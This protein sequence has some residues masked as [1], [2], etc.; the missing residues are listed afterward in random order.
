MIKTGFLTTRFIYILRNFRNATFHV[1]CFL[2]WVDLRLFPIQYFILSH[3]KEQLTAK[4]IL[5]RPFVL[6]LVIFNK[7][8][9]ASIWINMK[10]NGKTQNVSEIVV[11]NLSQQKRFFVNV[12]L[13]FS[14]AH[15]RLIRFGYF[16]TC[17]SA[18]RHPNSYLAAQNVFGY[19]KFLGQK[20]SFT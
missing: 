9:I 14:M 17:S 4:Q 12:T 20:W 3:D 8:C 15:Y 11:Y 19:C 6:T 7:T 5:L 10:T 18:K 2:Y 13:K 16:A 1:D